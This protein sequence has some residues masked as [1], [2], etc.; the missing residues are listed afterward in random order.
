LLLLLLLLY[1]YGLRFAMSSTN[2]Q[3][4]SSAA[5]IV[6]IE[7]LFSY[8]RLRRPLGWSDLL[9]L[10]YLPFGIVLSVTRMALFAVLLS[11]TLVLPRA[12]S[13]AVLPRLICAVMGIVVRE[14]NGSL[15][16]QA[17]IVAFNH[18]TDLDTWVLCGTFISRPVISTVTTTVQFIGPL[19]RKAF[20]TADP[21]WVP[22]KSDQ[23]DAR[24]VVRDSI[25]AHM[26][27]QRPEPITIAPEGG[28][29][30]GRVGL[31]QFKRFIFSLGIPVQPL[32]LRHH[33]RWP[34]EADWLGALWLSDMFWLCFFPFHVFSLTWLKPVAPRSDESPEQ[35]AKRVQTVMADE[36]KLVPTDHSYD[37][38]AKLRIK[39][40]GAKPRAY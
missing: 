27:A 6:P 30:N 3:H 17:P 12:V 35:F 15:R 8:R 33:D 22:P 7:S 18:V 11:A 36:L 23:I 29:T 21:I 32:C 1:L 28:V 14:R 37:A 19:L 20:S 38:K 9:W 40:Y 34:V 5:P 16:K 24:K 13:V 25:A 2:N 26:R 39:L 4:L 10:P 31:M